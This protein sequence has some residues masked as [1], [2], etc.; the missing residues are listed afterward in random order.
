[1]IGK[2][3]SDERLQLAEDDMALIDEIMRASCGREGCWT[4]FRHARR[5]D[6]P[7]TRVDPGRTKGILEDLE[8]KAEA[9]SA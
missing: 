8:V 7:G 3:S 6:G 2:I 1:M 4:S 5:H 9:V